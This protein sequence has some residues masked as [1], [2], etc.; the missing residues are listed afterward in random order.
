VLWAPVTADQFV[1]PGASGIPLGSGATFLFPF[2]GTVN[3]EHWAAMAI[4]TAGTVKR[5]FVQCVNN[6]DGGTSRTFAMRLNGVDQ[7]LA[8]TMSAGTNTCSDTSNTVA[9]VATDRMTTHYTVSGA[10]A[11]DNCAIGYV[12]DPTTTGRFILAGMSPSGNYTT[13]PDTSGVNGVSQSLL[14][15][16]AGSSVAFVSQATQACT[17]RSIAVRAASAPGSGVTTAYTLRVNGTDSAL[18]CS[19]TGT[20][21]NDNCSAST[22]VS[23][24]DDDLLTTRWVMTGAGLMGLPRISYAASV[25]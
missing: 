14:A 2:A 13:T 3:D 16:Q 10:P 15:S 5:L 11:D 22:D 7:S 21:S 4:P 9:V 24:A 17:V 20:G 23:V 12:F 18:T 8:C 1:L 25:P 6:V 19:F